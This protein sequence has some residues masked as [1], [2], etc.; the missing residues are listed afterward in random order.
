MYIHVLV[1]VMQ[2]RKTT[3]QHRCVFDSITV[4]FILLWKLRVA[5]CYVVHLVS[6]ANVYF[7]C[8]YI[9]YCSF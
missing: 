5:H 7:I 1:C 8:M 3:L 6:Y 9:N 4:L 2:L